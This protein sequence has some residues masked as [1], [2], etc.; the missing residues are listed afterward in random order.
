MPDKTTC[1]IC[2][3]PLGGLPVVYKE[4]SYNIGLGSTIEDF[5][6]MFEKIEKY[7]FCLQLAADLRKHEEPRPTM[8][9]RPTSAN[10]INESKPMDSANSFLQRF[11]GME[12]TPT[13]KN[14]LDL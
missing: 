12:L 1:G 3:K 9:M 14:P 6:L 11:R 7:P 5:A 2:K 10:E 13:G 4:P 8:E